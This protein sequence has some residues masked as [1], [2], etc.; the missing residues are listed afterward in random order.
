MPKRGAYPPLEG[1]P[2]LAGGGGVAGG[3]QRR[4]SPYLPQLLRQRLHLTRQVRV[5]HL[6]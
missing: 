6:L 2:A 1:V 3:G 5:P 4:D